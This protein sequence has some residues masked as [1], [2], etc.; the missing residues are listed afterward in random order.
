MDRSVLE[1][2]PHSVI[3]AMA[4]AAYAVGADQGYIYIRAEYPIAV[5]RLNIAIDQA[6][7]YGL[8]GKNIFNTGFN[9]DLELRLGAGAFVCGE[10][11]A[12]MTSIEGHRGEPR[13]RPP[14]PA[15]KGLFA[16]PT[17][18]NNVETYANITAII[19]NGADW[20]ASIGTEKSKG[21]KVFAVGGKINNTGLVEI[22]M[23]TTLREIIYD[24]G[25]GIPNGKQFK[26]A[27][28]GGPSGGCIPA[29]LID[30]P[31]D[32]DSLISI[33]S[34][35]GSGGLIVMDEDTCMVDIAKFFLEFTVD[36]SCGK[37]T[38]CRIGTKRLLEILTKITKGEGTLEDIDKLEELCYSIKNSALCGL[39]QTAPNPIL[40]TLRYFRD[41]YVAHVVDKK[42]PAGVCKALISYKIDADK[43]K[44][45]TKCARN[46]PVGAISGAVKQPHVIDGSKCVKC[47]VCVDNC[48][49]G[50]ITK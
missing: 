46:C 34:M 27:Q 30:T 24:I 11:T 45:C 12:L 49:F 33:G 8:L 32:Y 39:G 20:F 19:N 13:P 5:N 15:V 25:G 37:C 23:G 16:K 10:E 31:I 50:A 44:G 18:L 29:S 43:C 9:F 3:E 14:F 28:T 7:E 1:G 2:D 48:P 21:T 17:L 22:P 42:C 40:S 47:G 36:E 35:M 41:E 26:A 4:I 38:P 6:R